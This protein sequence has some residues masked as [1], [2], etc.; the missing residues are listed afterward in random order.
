MKNYVEIVW[1]KNVS[2]F[3]KF[4][5]SKAQIVKS[6]K[7][8]CSY[9]NSAVLFNPLNPRSDWYLISPYTTTAESITKAMRIRYMIIH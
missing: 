2:L 1:C 9:H 3:A 5:L 6:D 4:S 7:S 8:F